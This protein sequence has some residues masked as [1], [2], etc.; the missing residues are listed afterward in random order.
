MSGTRKN[1][2]ANGRTNRFTKNSTRMVNVSE[3]AGG[4]TVS[5]KLSPESCDASPAQ[6]IC[7]P[8]P[9]LKAKSLKTPPWLLVAVG[10][11]LET[12][13]TVPF[14][15]VDLPELSAALAILVAA[16]V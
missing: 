13:A 6:L 1:S 12:A 10:L 3:A 7:P 15:L 16:T 2:A 9:V 8:P 14:A 5:A 11:L 4:W